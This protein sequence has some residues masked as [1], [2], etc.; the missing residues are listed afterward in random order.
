MKAMNF[1]L[2]QDS[3]PDSRTKPNGKDTMYYLDEDN[4]PDY[5]EDEN[6]DYD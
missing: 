4:Y 3:K 2:G 1:I 6:E 5:D